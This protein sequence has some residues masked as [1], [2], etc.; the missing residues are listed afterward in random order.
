MET[1]RPPRYPIPKSV[2]RDPQ[3]LPGLTPMIANNYGASN[4]LPD[5]QQRMHRNKMKKMS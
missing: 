3:T 4:E 1:P 5:N 2:G